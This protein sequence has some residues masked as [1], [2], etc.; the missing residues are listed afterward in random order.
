MASDY[1]KIGGAWQGDKG[2]SFKLE[3]WPGYAYLFPNTHK[4]P[5]DKKPDFDICVKESVMP[6]VAEQ[7]MSEY[8][9]RQ[10]GQQ[11]NNTPSFPPSGSTSDID[12]LGPAFPAE[13]SGMDDVPF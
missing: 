7:Y 1:K 3:G 11:R 5:G 8:N 4:Q 12:D 2:I 6:D 10:D 9:K 13:A